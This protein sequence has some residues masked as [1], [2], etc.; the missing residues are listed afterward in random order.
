MAIGIVKVICN[1]LSI[2]CFQNVQYIYFNKNPVFGIT[3]DIEFKVEYFLT[4][5]APITTAAGSK[6]CDAFPNFG[7]K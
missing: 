5:K 4:L 6:F 3:T 2:F 7:N 1:V